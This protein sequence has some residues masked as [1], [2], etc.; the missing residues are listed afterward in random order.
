MALP[1]KNQ[2]GQQIGAAQERAVRRGDA[3]DHNMIAAAGAGMLA[4]DHEFIGTK[5]QLAG[6]FIDRFGGGDGFGPVVRGVNIHLDHARIGGNADHVQARIVRRAVAFDMHRQAVQFCGSLG[7]G[8]QFKVIFDLFDRRHE[9]AQPPVARFHRNRGAHAARDLGNHLFAAV[10]RRLGGGEGGFFLPMLRRGISAEIGQIAAILERVRR[11]HMRIVG[12][13]DIG[14]RAQR[15]PVA[16]GAVARH[17]EQMAT[18]QRPF[19]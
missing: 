7:S 1:M 14:Q 10:L 15:Q 6:L 13:F 4:V 5:A 3:A 16:D 19:F 18:P 2:A 11:M 8:D 17:Q 12:R 9:D